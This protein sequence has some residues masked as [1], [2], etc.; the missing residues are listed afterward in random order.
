M[1]NVGL[2]TS[3]RELCR[4]MSKC[5]IYQHMCDIHTNIIAL[6]VFG[7]I[8]WSRFTLKVWVSL[9]PREGA[10]LHQRGQKTCGLISGSENK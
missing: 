9:D 2:Q 8:E 6:V 7:N 1:A 10:F 3:K 4:Q 5:E